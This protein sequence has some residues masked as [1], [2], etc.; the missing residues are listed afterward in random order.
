VTLLLDSWPRLDLLWSF[1]SAAVLQLCATDTQ[2]PSFR[3]LSCAIAYCLSSPR[4]CCR[5]WT[6]AGCVNLMAISRR[7]KVRLHQYLIR[8]QVWSVMVATRK[9]DRNSPLLRDLH[10][11]R[12]PEDVA[13]HLVVLVFRRQST[14][15]GTYSRLQMTTHFGAF[16]LCRV[17]NWK[18]SAIVSSASLH[19]E[20]VSCN[21]LPL[22]VTATRS[23]QSFKTDLK[24]H[25]F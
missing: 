13:F 5:D 24:A 4:R 18:Q 1:R 21:G 20:S 7:L 23:L 6:T 3:Q 2:H 12:I 19:L 15:R 22:D 10:W 25:L 9:Y 16:D 17:I 11:L 8:Q 14:W